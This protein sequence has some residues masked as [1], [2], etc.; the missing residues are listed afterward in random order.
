MIFDA[1]GLE[2]NMSE[3]H[4]KQTL[5]LGLLPF[6][7]PLNPP[8]GLACLKGYLA[9]YA[10][11]VQLVDLNVADIFKQLYDEYFELLKT[12]VPEGKRGNFY[13]IGHDVMENHLM[14]HL[15][16]RE[17]AGLVAIVREVVQTNF[18]VTAADEVV[19]S[20]DAVLAE[21]FRRLEECFFEQFDRI[22]PD[23]LGLSVVRGN[24]ASSLFIF[25]KVKA[26]YPDVLTV[27]GGP[28]FSQ[29]LDVGSPNMK[30]FLETASYIDKLIV[31]EGELLLRGLLDGRLNPDQRIYTKQDVRDRILDLERAPLADFSGMNLDYYTYMANYSSRS[32]PFQ[33]SFCAETI[34]WGN[35]RKKTGT[36]IYQ[37][38][39]AL[40]ETSRNQLFLMCDSLLNPVISDLADVCVQN[41]A[42][43]YWDGYLRVDRQACDADIVHQWRRGGFYRARLGVE[44]GSPAVL[45]LMGKKIDIQQIKTVVANLAEAGVKTTTYWVIGHPGE[46][47]EDF[48]MTLGLVEE[49]ADFIYEAECNPFRYFYSGQVSSSDWEAR[50]NPHPLY[51]DA[52]LEA[53]LIQTWDL[54]TSPS[55]EERYERVNRFVQHCRRLGIPNPYSM[56]EIHEADARWA[57]LHRNAVPAITEFKKSEAIDENLAVTRLLE[58]HFSGDEEGDFDF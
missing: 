45:H 58:G 56:R 15:N 26:A 29:G 23:V 6:W 12:A 52:A 32:C 40:S 14:A 25:Q 55:R 22:K 31:G 37:E 16:R 30:A 41:R 50:H 11:D 47:E 46:T 39:K 3:T 43:L 27:M 48:A 35:Y 54:D 9:E 57:A 18:F 4:K 20:M 44:S 19:L 1:A 21:I 42:S 8:L 7:T 5:L 17:N 13:N 24:I 36:K 33:C 38:M 2:K 10:L 34:Y 53:L 28:V 49:L 51:S